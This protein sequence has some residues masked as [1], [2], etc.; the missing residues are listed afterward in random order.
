MNIPTSWVFILKAGLF[1]FIMG[2]QV[3]HAWYDTN[4]NGTAPDWHYRVPVQI[5]AGTPVNSTIKISVDFQSLVTQA[6][7]TGTFDNNSPRIVRPNE[8][9]STIQEYTD[10]IYNGVIDNA[11]NQRGE[12][13]FIL[14]DAGPTTYYLYFDTTDNGNKAPNP[15]TTLNGNFEHS[16]GSTP[17]NWTISAVNA[18]GAQDNTVY[19]TAY[20]AKFNGNIACGEGLI[21]NADN[22]P[23]H[24]NSATS[25][26]GRKWHLIGYRN[27]C[28]DG[29]S[30]TKESIR[31]SRTIDVP[32]TSPGNLTFFFQ[33]QAFDDARFDFF[34]LAING[35]AVN[36][37]QLGI[38][39][40]GNHLT[41]NPSGLGRRIGY[42]TTLVDSG[43]QQAS[44]DLTPYAGTSITVRFSTNFFTDNFF[45]NWIKLDDVEWSVATATLG[46]PEVTS[47]DI[48]VQK[49][50]VTISDPVNGT[51]TPKAI[52]GAIIEYTLTV[53]NSGNRVVDN[54]TTVLTDAI[55]ANTSLV[56]ND[57]DVPGSGPIK[58]LE[59]TSGLTYTYTTLNSTAD[60]LSFSDGSTNNGQ[61]IY[62]YNPIPD[63]DGIDDNVKHIKIS[64]QGKFKAADVN[65]TPT[66]Q[67]KFR[68][69]VK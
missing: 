21:S 26:T 40:T 32:A 19:D 14:Q 17:T 16:S 55:P 27:N 4:T 25:T 52:P 64:T 33:L 49:Q 53:T 54:N 34:Q 51:V 11:N 20:N 42:S 3:T 60:N 44:L 58:F 57:I 37:Q 5:P 24:N 65:G 1:F 61:L 8:S 67:V 6:G 23:H 36:H 48:T 39:N 30:G 22:A 47:P 7:G 29:K 9:L 15:Q 31:L 13:K 18:N 35:T 28:E 45:R 38:A 62:N 12:I 43:W 46:T 56:L 63:A 41:I 2:L 59:G 10:G 66:F 50:S 69:R 68:L